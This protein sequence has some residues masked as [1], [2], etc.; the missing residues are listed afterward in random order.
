VIIVERVSALVL[1]VAEMSQS[2][3]ETSSESSFLTSGVNVR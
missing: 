3:S 1:M 2:S